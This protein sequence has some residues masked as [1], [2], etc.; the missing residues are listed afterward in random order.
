MWLRSKARIIID[1]NRVFYRLK[2]EKAVFSCF[3]IFAHAD[4]HSVLSFYQ[5]FSHINGA[6]NENDQTLDDILHI[7]INAKEGQPHKD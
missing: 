1:K 7:G 4:W 5:I 3:F 2:I 6:S